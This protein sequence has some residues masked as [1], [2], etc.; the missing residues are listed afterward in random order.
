MWRQL[1]KAQLGSPTDPI[2]G[3]NVRDSSIHTHPLM[4][5]WQQP[6][7]KD[8]QRLLRQN[9]HDAHTNKVYSTKPQ[10]PRDFTDAPCGCSSD[11]ALQRTVGS[12]VQAA[13]TAVM[14]FLEL[15]AFIPKR[16]RLRPGSWLARDH[17]SK[18]PNSSLHMHMQTHS[19]IFRDRS[20]VCCRF[21]D[22]I[23]SIPC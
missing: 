21:D 1:R 15:H 18:L 20:K 17:T 12:G 5:P 10:A 4:Q 6:Q 11:S 16:L 22:S 23:A 13:A 7:M 19:T 8:V 2:T 3:V 9:V 14:N